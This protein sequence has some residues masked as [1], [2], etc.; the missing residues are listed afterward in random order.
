MVFMPMAAPASSRSMR[1]GSKESACQS[2]ADDGA[3]RRVVGADE[4]GLGAIPVGRPRFGPEAA[5]AAARGEAVGA[6]AAIW[7]AR[8]PGRR[9]GCHRGKQDDNEWRQLTWGSCDRRL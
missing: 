6:C 2:R 4:P 7:V 1:A 3:G 8:R 9:P 5:G